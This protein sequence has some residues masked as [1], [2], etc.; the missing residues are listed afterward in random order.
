MV[1]NSNYLDI[2]ID[3]NIRLDYRVGQVIKTKY[4][5]LIFGKLK[6]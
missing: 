5:I 1:K 4:L 6:K 3:C 2:T